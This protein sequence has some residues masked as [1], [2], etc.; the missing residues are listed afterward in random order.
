VYRWFFDASCDAIRLLDEPIWYER[1]E[2]TP[3]EVRVVDSSSSLLRPPHRPPSPWVPAAGAQL[4]FY[5]LMLFTLLLVIAPHE[6]FPILDPLHLPLLAALLALAAYV[7]DRVNRGR[8]L[9]VREPEIHLVILLLA[10]ALLSVPTS[11]WPGGSFSIV[12]NIFA[13]SIMIFWLLANVLTTARRL[14]AMLWLL[15]LCS[16]VPA[17][18][19]IKNYRAGR[20]MEAEPRVEGYTGLSANPNDLALLL[21]III[22]L[23][24]GLLIG[25]RSRVS[26]VLLS[27]VVLLCVAGVTVTKSRGGFIYLVTSVVVSL[28]LIR[29]ARLRLVPVVLVVF[30]CM[31]GVEGFFGRME[32]IGD[33]ETPGSGQERWDDMKK[34]WGIMLQNP[35]HGVGIGQNTLALNDKGTSWGRVHNVY[36]EIGSE[37]GI[38]GL[39][40]YLLLV[41]HCLR[42]LKTAVEIW[43]GQRLQLYYLTQGLRISFIG[44][45]VAANFY[46]IA[47]NFPFYYL[48]GLAVAVKVLAR[49]H[50]RLPVPA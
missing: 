37:L 46:P 19:V 40:V 41:R 43:R 10:L 14:R 16:T 26:R 48:A 3:A 1:R 31:T 5:A 44:F 13:K 7:V 35:V 42:S 49:K 6:T 39:V 32:T 4:P 17:L 28:I 11:H 47:Y 2:D 38:A 24:I 29:G 9:T 21:N 27:L 30:L 34:A 23:A 25:T 12:I 50:R 36:L 18:V 8:S 20:F 22:P 45:V 33:V 15:A